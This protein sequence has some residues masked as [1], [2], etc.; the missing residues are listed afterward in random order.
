MQDRLLSELRLTTIKTISAANNFLPKFIQRF[1]QRFAEP[2]DPSTPVFEKQLIPRE[3]DQI[4]IIA[5]EPIINSG[6]WLSFENKRYLP[7][8]NGEYVYLKPHTKV[9]VIKSFTG[10]LYLTTDQDEVYDLFCISTY[11]F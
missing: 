7:I 4:L 9:L 10:K 11:Q 1:N 3:I 6:H 2:I 5:N 8:R